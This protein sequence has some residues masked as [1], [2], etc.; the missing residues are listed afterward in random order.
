MNTQ[1]G[2]VPS[3]SWGL[4]PSKLTT[5]KIYSTTKTKNQPINESLAGKIE[6]KRRRRRRGLSPASHGDC[7]LQNYY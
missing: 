3:F 5:K 6:E 1:K 4:F 2:T 7:S